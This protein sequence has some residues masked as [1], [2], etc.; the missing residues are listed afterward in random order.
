MKK[1]KD[2]T[3]TMK[4]LEV[5]YGTSIEELLR[6]LYI[7]EEKTIDEIS[8]ELILAPATVFDWLKLAGIRTR[9]MKFE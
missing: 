2:K 6:R 5:Q 7:D 9:K 4:R 8:K 1:I 3:N